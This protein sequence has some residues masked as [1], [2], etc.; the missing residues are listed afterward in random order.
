[1]HTRRPRGSVI[2][3]GAVLLALGALTVDARGQ[4]DLSDGRGRMLF[5]EHGCAACHTVGALGVPAGPDLSHVGSKY[6]AEYL[7]EWLADPASRRPWAHM[8]NLQLTRPEIAAL[9]E[10]LASQM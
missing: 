6:S 4:A 1:V 9:A 8:P 3:V 2:G 7:R 10:F 5:G